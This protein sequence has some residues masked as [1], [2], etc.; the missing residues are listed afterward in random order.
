[1]KI[2]INDTLYPCTIKDTHVDFKWDNRESKAITLEMDAS[3]ASALFVDDAAW[4]IVYPSFGGVDENGNAI[5]QDTEQDMSDFCVAGSIVD[6][7]DGTVTVKMGKKTD[8]EMLAELREVLN[9]D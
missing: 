2:K 8:G 6:N 5:T 1:M 3:T 7:R 4:S 9:D